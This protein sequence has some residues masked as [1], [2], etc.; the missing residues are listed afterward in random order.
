MRWYPSKVDWWL[1]PLLA[2]PPFAGLAVTT[3]ALL[4]KNWPE[5]LIGLGVLAFVILLYA[6]VIFPIRYGIDREALIVRAG[7]FRKEIPLNTI[8]RVYP[9]MNPLSSPALSLHRLC[10][11]FGPKFYERVLISPKERKLFLEDLAQKANLVCDGE[12]LSREAIDNNST[13]E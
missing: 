2:L 9:T 10:I 8:Q 7:L 4:Q 12:N 13:S 11:E 6:V 5:T 3:Q 1:V